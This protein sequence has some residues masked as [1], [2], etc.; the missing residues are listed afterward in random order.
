MTEEAEEAFV[1]GKMG[2]C[3]QFQLGERD[4][5]RIEIQR[6]NRGRSG[7]QI[8]QDIAAARGNG[9]DP[10]VG[11][12]LQRVQIDAGVFPDLIIDKALEHQG[13]KPFQHA[14]WASRRRLMCGLFQK[15]VGHVPPLSRPLFL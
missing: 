14:A 11:P 7:G 4:M 5:M 2:K 13:E 3:G 15:R 12:K 9:D 6:D 10:V 8:I 1:I